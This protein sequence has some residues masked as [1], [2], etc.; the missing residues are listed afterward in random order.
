MD[1][2]IPQRQPHST[3]EEYLTAHRFAHE[4]QKEMGKFLKAVILFGSGARKSMVP[5]SDIDVL[6]LIDDVSIVVTRDVADAYRIAIEQI[7]GKVSRR[8]HVVTLRLT[9]F[10]DYMRKGDPIGINMLRD[11][12]SLY[13]T[14]FFAPLQLLLKH[15]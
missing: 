4:L 13:D 2:P 6:V 15:G 9:A 7:I 10:W 3:N 5:G 8:L 14:G 12:I 11:G 1:V